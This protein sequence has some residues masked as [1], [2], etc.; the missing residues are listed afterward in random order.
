MG[1]EL[2]ML[3]NLVDSKRISPVQIAVDLGY[4]SPTTVYNWFQKK[5]I[6][7]LALIKVRAYLEDLSHGKQSRRHR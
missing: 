4:R 3:K 7:K 6:P 1:Q 2:R 5:K